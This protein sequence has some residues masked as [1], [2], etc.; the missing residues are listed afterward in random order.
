[1]KGLPLNSNKTQLGGKY[2]PDRQLTRIK[3]NE[4]MNPADFYDK[5]NHPQVQEKADSLE[6]G[7]LNCPHCGSGEIKLHGQL[8]TTHGLKQHYQCQ[9]CKEIWSTVMP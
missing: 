3:E 8:S 2:P 1:M 4:N 5:K 6:R 9:F 7:K